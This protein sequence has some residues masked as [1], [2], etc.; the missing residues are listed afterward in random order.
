[1]KVTTAQ[2]KEIISGAVRMEE[3]DNM[4]FFYRFTKE[5]ESL[6]SKISDDFHRKTFST[7]GIRMVFQTDSSSLGLKVFTRPGSSRHFFSFDVFVDG[8]CIGYLD[9][10]SEQELPANYT[11]APFPLGEFEKTFALGTGLKIVT[12]YFPW[13]VAA[14]LQEMTLDDGSILVPVKAPKRLLMFGDSI[15]HGYDALRPS[16]HYSAQLSKLLNAEVINKAIGNEVFF[17]A[18]AE[19][20]ENF[21]PDYITVAYGTN[22]WNRT[23]RSAFLENCRAF[24]LALHNN[25]PSAKIFA[26]VPIW[27]K[28]L[29]E[30]REYGSFYQ[31]EK[32]IQMIVNDLDNVAFLSCFDFVP[33]DSAFYSD[34]VLHPNDIGFEHYSK[35]ICKEFT[36]K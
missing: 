30:H 34:R 11:T 13:S 19:T 9:N 16:N 6:Y 23:C 15:T 21:A 4:V 29:E 17:P 26:M 7:A 3:R 35:S 33:K 28:D 20:V 10:F 8:K 22:D 36:S 32:D 5:Q 31:V 12:V 14:A 1:M 27:R 25:Y 18:L 24:Y 2:I